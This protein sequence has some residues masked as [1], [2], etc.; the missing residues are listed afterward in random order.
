ME[1]HISPSNRK[2]SAHIRGITHRSTSKEENSVKTLLVNSI[3]KPQTN[4][5]FKRRL[6]K[7]SS[8]ES[9]FYVKNLRITYANI[10][11]RK[12]LFSKKNV[13]LL[14]KSARDL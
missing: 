10:T 14:E 5:L 6:I 12:L 13:L 7:S 2:K 4:F 11:K 1:E 9:T 8:I 3:K